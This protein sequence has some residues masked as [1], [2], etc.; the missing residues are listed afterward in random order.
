MEWMR[1]YG[2]WVMLFF[3]ALGVAVRF[4]GIYTTTPEENRMYQAMAKGL[5]EM[6]KQNRLYVNS[7]FGR[8][9]WKQKEK[10]NDSDTL[11][12]PYYDSLEKTLQSDAPGFYD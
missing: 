8:N 4:I 7:P 9:D 11:L 5:S 10:G 2:G 1:K 12:I 6:N 3:A